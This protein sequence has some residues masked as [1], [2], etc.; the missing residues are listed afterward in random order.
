MKKIIILL[1]LIAIST[2]VFAQDM[3]IAYLDIN[4]VYNEFPDKIAAE[5]Q[6]NKEAQQWE[7]E[8]IQKEQEI[9]KLREEYNNLPPITTEQRKEEKKALIE[10]KEREYQQLAEKL[11]TQAMQRQTELLEP[12]SNNIVNAINTVAEE[13][14][15]D[16]VI[17][18]LQGEVV[19]YANPELDI[20]E[21]VIT[22]LNKKSE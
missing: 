18:S 17:N 1:T 20:T 10:K 22:E 8:L 4:K 3:K 13:N 19:L 14:G 6:F 7:Q 11:R 5:E 12:I 2:V 16:M 15:Y 21:D 9:Q